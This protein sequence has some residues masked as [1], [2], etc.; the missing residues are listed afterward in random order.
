MHYHGHAAV[1]KAFD[2][3]K[4]PSG[5]VV[6]DAGSGFGGC[7]RYWAEQLGL[8]H[9]IISCEYNCEFHQLAQMATAALDQTISCRIEQVCGDLVI[10]NFGVTLDG[11]YSF[12]VFLHIPKNEL[13]KLFKNLKSQMKPGAKIY[14]EDY[15]LKESRK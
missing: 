15:Y 5:G 6:L 14:I 8:N 2:F 4:I 3:L 10:K 9:H 13:I 11:V 7:G 12:L 1:E